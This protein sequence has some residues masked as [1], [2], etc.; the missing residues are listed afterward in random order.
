[1][2]SLEWGCVKVLRDRVR[3]GTTD[4]HFRYGLKLRDPAGFGRIFVL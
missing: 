4:Y 3:L 2:A 1:M